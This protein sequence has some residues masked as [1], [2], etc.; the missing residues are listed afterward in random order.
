MNNLQTTS[1]SYHIETLFNKYKQ[2]TSSTLLKHCLK[3]MVEM[4]T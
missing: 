3:V 2:T 4:E 1:S